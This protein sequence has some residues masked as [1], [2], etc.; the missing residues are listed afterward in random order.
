M[1]KNT[2]YVTIHVKTNGKGLT[3]LDTAL[4]ETLKLAKSVETAINKIGSKTPKGWNKFGKSV[5]N[6]DKRINDFNNSISD[7]NDKIKKS[8]VTN[9]ARQIDQVGDSANKSVKKNNKLSKSQQV[10]GDNTRKTVRQQEKLQKVMNKPQSYTPPSPLTNAYVKANTARSI[11]AMYDP[12]SGSYGFNHSSTFGGT[13]SLKFQRNMGKYLSQFREK[14]GNFMDVGM[15]GSM[16]LGGLGLKNYLVDVPAKAETNNYLLSLMGDGGATGNTLYNTLDRVTDKLPLS[17]QS[18]VQ[19]LNAFKAATGASASE[20]NSIIPEFANFGAV[21]QMLSGSTELAETAMIK[22]AHAYQGAYAGVDQFGITEEAV[23]RVLNEKY[24]GSVTTENMTVTQFMEAVNSIVGDASGAMGTFNGRV[25]MLQKSLSRAG[26]N[27]WSGG[28]GTM[29]GGGVSALTA[30]LD[31]GD[32]FIAKLALMS[33]S[34][35]EM[36]TGVLGGTGYF[37]QAAGNMGGALDLFKDARSVGFGNYFKLIS[38]KLSEAEYGKLMAQGKIDDMGRIIAGTPL[39]ANSTV[40]RAEKERAIYS[41][42]AMSGQVEG[43]AS[44]AK[45]RMNSKYLQ[46]IYGLDAMSDAYDVT[47]RGAVKTSKEFKEAAK[48]SNRDVI[49]SKRELREFTTGGFRTKLRIG[50]KSSFKGVG[51]ALHGRGSYAGASKLTRAGGTLKQTLS[52]LTSFGSILS[53]IIPSIGIFSGALIAAAGLFAAFNFSLNNSKVTQE[54][55]NNAGSKLNDAMLNIGALFGTITQA[56]GLTESGGLD[57]VIEICNNILDAISAIADFVSNIS[58]TI[59]G[60]DASAEAKWKSKDLDYQAALEASGITDAQL[61]E[62]YS[63]GDKNFLAKYPEAVNAR[64]Q[65][66]YWSANGWYNPDTGK[67]EQG[68]YQKTYGADVNRENY[69]DRIKEEMGAETK[70]QAKSWGET[71]RENSAKGSWWDTFLLSTGLPLLSEWWGNSGNSNE[72]KTSSTESTNN[73]TSNNTTASNNLGIQKKIPTSDLID[74]SQKISTN[75]IIDIAS[76]ISTNDI[77][78]LE[79]IKM[80]LGDAFTS[81]FSGD[82]WK[83][84]TDGLGSLWNQITGGGDNQ[85]SGLVKSTNPNVVN[86]PQPQQQQQTQPTQF[87]PNT[88]GMMSGITTALQNANPDTTSLANNISTS[89]STNLQTSLTTSLPMSIQTALTTGIT[90]SAESVGLQGQTI[91][92]NLKTG[93]DMGMADFSTGVDTQISNAATSV[94][95]HGGEF[96]S[97]GQTLGT[98]AKDGF[99]SGIG[100]FSDAASAEMDDA[101]AAITSRQGEFYAAGYANGQAAAKGASD[102]ADRHSPGL[103][104]RMFRDEISD[105][106]NFITSRNRDF[107]YGG[108]DNARAMVV[109]SGAGNTGFDTSTQLPDN[110]SNLPTTNSNLSQFKNNNSDFS[111][112]MG[113]SDRPIIIN[114]NIEKVDSKQRVKEVA[115]A[116]VQVFRFNNETAGRLASNPF[117]D[118]G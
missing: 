28:L 58:K 5:E 6:V 77:F 80:G 91:A 32:G 61:N 19:P 71:V 102:G 115:E 60:H 116:V 54:K 50:A 110:L 37:L 107:Y 117:P 35:A 47:S 11:G 76:K 48:K 40:A 87:A 56:L 104:A 14:M 23:G 93:F 17:M 74:S 111:S 57:G 78:D 113:A 100:G 45:Q 82:T 85:A 95:N 18:I 21:A 26:K 16:F 109:G 89:L 84:I 86:T 49:K 30:F 1:A 65:R 83:G 12:F 3:E 73:L 2:Y 10:L 51:D 46:T 70:Q 20:I 67:F 25:Q 38:G 106:L 53:G 96:N 4:R 64:E 92:N 59:S 118:G 7:T 66:D 42:A 9:Y 8:E 36:F 68:Y 105:S 98:S 22:L 81:L 27:L 62:A 69:N 112:S 101:L 29:L 99:A 33:A 72:N 41:S 39:P 75:D 55:W 13:G 34:V 88:Q 44:G 79:S 52:G 63:K 103:M 24:G 43:R 114:N 94:S 15:M 90:T 97:A 108:Y 31:A